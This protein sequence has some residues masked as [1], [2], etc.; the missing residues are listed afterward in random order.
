VLFF[1]DYINISA[2]LA[3]GFPWVITDISLNALVSIFLKGPMED[4]HSI[5]LVQ[6]F[7]LICA[8]AALS[9]ALM[10]KPI[11]IAPK[12]SWRFSFHAQ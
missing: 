3:K 11:D 8:V 5:L 7:C 12:A 4:D 10:A 6:F 9:W 2:L 1:G